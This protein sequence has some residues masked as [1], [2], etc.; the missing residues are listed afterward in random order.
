MKKIIFGLL[1]VSM[2]ASGCKKGKDA[3]AVTKENIAGTYKLMSLKATVN[4]VGPLDADQ[5]DDCEKDDLYKLNVDNTFQYVDAG[6]VCDPAG[7][8]SGTWQL[9]DKV[10]SSESYP[11][12]NGTISSFDGT[13]L[14]VTITGTED[15]MSYTLVSTFKKQ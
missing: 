14:E 1:A 7:D 10:I 4:G 5:R 15:G 13:N 6:T 2:I 8:V 9:V 3:P 12:L 11:D